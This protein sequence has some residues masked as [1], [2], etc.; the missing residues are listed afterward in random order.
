MDVSPSPEALGS[1]IALFL[2]NN[3]AVRAITP[4]L[5]TSTYAFG[6]HKHIASGQFAW[7]IMLVLAVGLCVYMRQYP[8][9]VETK[10]AE[11][12]SD[13]GLDGSHTTVD[14]QIRVL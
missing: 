10:E 2:S 5:A 13:N 6:V 8:G 9:T 4:S 14:R 3:L 12:P 7:I 11:A 1:V